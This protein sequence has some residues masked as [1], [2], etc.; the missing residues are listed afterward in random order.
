MVLRPLLSLALLGLA[1]AQDSKDSS[2]AD[3]D[4]PYIFEA[5]D[6]WIAKRVIRKDANLA[7]SVEKLAAAAEFEVPLPG[8]NLKVTIRPPGDPPPSSIPAPDRLLALSDI[9][10]NIGALI[11]LLRAGQVVDDDLQ[12]T[13]GKGQLVF[14]GDLF[15][16]GLN[17]TECLWLLYELEGRARAK[18]GDVH[19]ILGNHEV[20]N[21]TGDFR[22]VRNKYR[23]NAA[24]LGE[25]LEDLHARR[26]VLGR[27]LRSRNAI[28][29]IGDEI[30]VHGGISPAVAESKVPIATLNDALRTGLA[31]DAWPKV[32]EGHLK[33]VVDGKEGLVWYRGYVKDP[34]DSG[35]MDAILAAV[36]ARRVIVGHTVV[37]NI[38]FVLG[39]RVLALDVRH[40]KGGSQAAI[41]EG[42]TWSRLHSDGRREKLETGA[43]ATPR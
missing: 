43:P 40:A 8:R 2:S 3:V 27:W 10:G 14:V 20:M 35:K 18:G 28:M 9:E 4:G 7:A 21:L 15:D 24:L 22:Y 39:G 11:D 25:K 33:L 31:A 37:E 41:R 13:F 6:G 32:K 26:T 5:A 34:I 36:D 12:W 29:K 1:A 38:G 42:G 17:V 30:F 23:E 16:R 19:F